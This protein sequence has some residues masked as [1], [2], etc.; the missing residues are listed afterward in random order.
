MSD[1]AGRS[2]G[3][4]CPPSQTPGTGGVGPASVRRTPRGPEVQQ[5]VPF[6]SRSPWHAPGRSPD[7]G[8]TGCGDASAGQ[9]PAARGG[10]GAAQPALSGDLQD[11]GT[12]VIW[13]CVRSSAASASSPAL[14][15]RAACARRAPGRSEHRSPRQRRRW[16]PG[17]RSPAGQRVSAA[18]ATPWE[19]TRCGC[20]R[21]RCRR[22]ARRPIHQ[23]G[24]QHQLQEGGLRGHGLS[25]P[26][27]SV[28]RSA[29][30]ARPRAMVSVPLPVVARSPSHRARPIGV[31]AADGDAG[32]APS[33]VTAETG[34][35]RRRWS[36]R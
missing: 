3:A 22:V 32:A 18:V 19:Y 15:P 20:A 2:P 11:P 28:T 35:S 10:G 17:A 34:I 4:A 30:T 27:S 31:V 16:L 24:Q 9:R 12:A 1:G 25:P 33:G 8:R 13:A 21:S 7:C 36:H 29:G 6:S 23:G 5:P 26:S 14:A